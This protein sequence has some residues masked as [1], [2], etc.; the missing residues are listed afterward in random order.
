MRRKR[1]AQ[2]LDNDQLTDGPAGPGLP[3]GPGG[4]GGP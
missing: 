2:K 1:K 3:T 4:P